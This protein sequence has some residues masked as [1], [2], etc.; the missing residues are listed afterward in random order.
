ML[1]RLLKENKR[2]PVNDLIRF[3][4]GLNQQILNKYLNFLFYVN[5][6]HV[7]LKLIS[8]SLFSIFIDY[9]QV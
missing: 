3:I 1:Q 5:K 7:Y 6:I 9:L 2:K 8:F 4:N